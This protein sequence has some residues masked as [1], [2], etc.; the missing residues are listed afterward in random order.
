MNDANAFPAP[1]EEPFFEAVITPHRSLSARGFFIVMALV[2][3]ICFT[4]GLVFWALGAW[5]IVGFLGLDVALVWFAFRAN[6][7]AARAYETVSVSPARLRIVRT[8][9][10]GRRRSTEMN[11]YWT[12][13]EAEHD[14]EFGLMGLTVTSRGRRERIGDWLSPP[15]REDFARALANALH[16]ARTPAAG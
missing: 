1:L 15:E 11:P 5:P 7:R 13:L 16:E 2:G 6:Y 9:V 8:D 14:E 4:C 3:G 12:R 10:R